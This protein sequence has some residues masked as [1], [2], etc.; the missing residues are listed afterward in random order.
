MGIRNCHQLIAKKG[1]PEYWANRGK[2]KSDVAI[3]VDY[4]FSYGLSHASS[5]PKPPKA[6]LD[7]LL[8][9]GTVKTGKQLTRDVE[10]KAKQAAEF[11][12]SVE[13]ELRNQRKNYGAASPPL[14][15]LRLPSQLPIPSLAKCAPEVLQLFA[16]FSCR[17]TLWLPSSL[18]LHRSLAKSF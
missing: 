14:D 7:D 2:I 5:Y 17:I 15:Q 8:K 6:T 4:N 3:C 1:R 9:S 18:T 16:I 13:D 11:A 12:K 10:E